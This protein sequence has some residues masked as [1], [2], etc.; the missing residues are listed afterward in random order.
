M[1]N[2]ELVKI[3]LSHINF[4]KARQR[5]R[6]QLLNLDNTALEDVGISREEA[7]EEGSK[8]FWKSG[9]SNQEMTDHSLQRIITALE[10]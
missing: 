7:L 6:R 8:P 1:K 10:L 2:L 9:N 4:L 3:L 5:T